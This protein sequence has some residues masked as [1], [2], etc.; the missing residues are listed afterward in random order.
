MT[1]IAT[2]AVSSGPFN[3]QYLVYASDMTVLVLRVPPVL[4]VLIGVVRRAYS[5]KPWTG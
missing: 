5:S 3:D 4:R 1:K 2:T